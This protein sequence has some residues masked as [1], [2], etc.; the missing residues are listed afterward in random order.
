M[1]PPVG[2]RGKNKKKKSKGGFWGAASRL[3]GDFIENAI[4]IGTSAPAGFYNT[5]KALGKSLVPGRDGDEELFRIAK[6]SALGAKE[7]AR[8]PLRRP[9]DTFLLALA[10]ASAGLGT[11]SRVGAGVKAAKA[12]ESFTAAARRSPRYHRMVEIPPGLEFKGAPKSVTVRK[13]KNRGK[14]ASVRRNVPDSL[15][16]Q[17]SNKVPVTLMGPM[18][19][20]LR[21]ATGWQ[22]AINISTRLSKSKGKKTAKYGGALARQ[23]AQ[24]ALNDRERFA[25]QAMAGMTQAQEKSQRISDKGGVGMELWKTLPNALRTSMYLRG[26]YYAQNIGGTGLFLGAQQSPLRLAANTKDL[27]ALPPHERQFVEHAAGAG[28]MKSIGEG[29]GGLGSRF[30]QWLA[31]KANIPESKM[32]PLALMEEMRLANTNPQKMMANPYANSAQLAMRRGSEA[33]GDYGRLGDKEMAFMRSQIPIFY[34]MSKAFSRYAGRYPV[35]HPIQASLLAALAQEGNQ[36][37]DEGFGG[38]EPL[39]WG[40][41]HVPSGAGNPAPEA[42]RNPQNIYP[43]S[44]GTDLA[45]EL[46][47]PFTRGGPEYGVNV[48]QHVGPG[49]DALY[50][51]LFGRDITTGWQMKEE[52]AYQPGGS[53]KGALDNALPSLI[54][55]GDFM[56]LRESK[57]FE[58][59][60]NREEFLNWLI[61]PWAVERRVNKPAYSKQL[62]QQTAQRRRRAATARKYGG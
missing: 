59:M 16:S 35:T 28:G 4:D 41:Y 48:G 2:Q 8:H 45:R 34:P 46:Y 54:P 26:R 44:P 18:A 5:T 13:G 60:S 31:E 51:A 1:P 6:A 42:I 19:M 57:S 24:R 43:F 7:T 52:D 38:H 29:S 49:V 3:P 33:V 61:G 15:R 21:Y 62:R 53:V 56:N 39:W 47:G 50:Q 12:G 58:P 9:A 32:R 10:G 23:H 17:D 25:H 30:T 27:R 37:Q 40:N 55:G 11:A 22:P 36:V 14:Q 20:P